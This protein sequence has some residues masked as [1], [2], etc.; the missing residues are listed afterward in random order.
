MTTPLVIVWFA[1]IAVS[2]AGAAVSVLA[3]RR[4]AGRAVPIASLVLKGIVVVAIAGFFVALRAGV[5]TGWQD[6]TTFATI[7]VLTSA[8]LVVTLGLDLFCVVLL[9]RAR[10]GEE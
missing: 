6:L 1:L 3:L 2:L 7:L 5:F 9:V 8:T 4:G 10:R